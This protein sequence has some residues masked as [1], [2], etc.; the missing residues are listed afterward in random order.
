[1]V[2]FLFAGLLTALGDAVTGLI[3]LDNYWLQSLIAGAL[4]VIFTRFAFIGHEASHRWCS[5]P[6]P[7]TTY[8]PLEG[9]GA[10]HVRSLSESCRDLHDGT[11]DQAGEHRVRLRTIHVPTHRHAEVTPGNQQAGPETGLEAIRVWTR[12]HRASPTQER[13]V[14]LFEPVEDRQIRVRPGVEKREVASWRELMKRNPKRS[15]RCSCRRQ[16]HSGRAIVEQYAP[17]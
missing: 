11:R 8:R 5:P 9:F 6:R 17:T 16:D 15:D 2:L 4:G 12:Q 3:L 10:C 1:L 7:P 13:R 14:C